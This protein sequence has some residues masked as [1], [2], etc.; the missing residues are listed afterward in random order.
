[1]T[2]CKFDGTDLPLNFKY[3]WDYTG[4]M[5]VVKTL[6]ADVVQ[7]QDFY[8]GDQYISF[9]CPFAT[10]AIHNLFYNAFIAQDAVVFI[11]Y[12]SSSGDVL[13][14]EFKVREESGLFN[15]SGKMKVIP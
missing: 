13:I 15:L 8:D 12:E 1:M 2:Q 11:D 9:L 3:D 7:K 10:T 6:T 4:R 5:S 14:T